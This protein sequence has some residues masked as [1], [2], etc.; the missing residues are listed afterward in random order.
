MWETNN[1]RTLQF[2][3]RRSHSLS[4]RRKRTVA[5]PSRRWTR[6]DDA[7]A[8]GVVSIALGQCCRGI[9][10]Y[11]DR[12]VDDLCVECVFGVD[13]FVV[14][15]RKS[16]R[17]VMPL[18][19]FTSLAST[20]GATFRHR[21]PRNQC[22]PTELPDRRPQSF[23]LRLRLPDSLGRDSDECGEVSIFM[24]FLSIILCSNELLDAHAL[25]AGLAAGS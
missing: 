6:R 3:G 22:H 24:S 21:A 12:A 14:C 1:F 5:G 17:F 19:F 25:F 2:S 15:P 8:R 10:I 7:E 11:L 23:D 16:L 18:G 4:S 20:N 9:L 13:L